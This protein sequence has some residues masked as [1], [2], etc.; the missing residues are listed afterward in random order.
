MKLFNLIKMLI[1]LTLLVFSSILYVV[2]GSD[3][4][5]LISFFVILA[6][7]LVLIAIDMKLNFRPVRKWYCY[8]IITGVSLLFM[9][10]FLIV[11]N[12]SFKERSMYFLSY[13]S[14]DILFYLISD[15]Y[16]FFKDDDEILFK[17]NESE[18]DNVLE[19]EIVNE[20]DVYFN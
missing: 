14:V 7:E 11:R 13:V 5:N 18:E 3:T 12:L 19:A 4:L 9:I 8:L 16:Y 6:I 2:D 20:K 10:S 1:E 15:F 17:K